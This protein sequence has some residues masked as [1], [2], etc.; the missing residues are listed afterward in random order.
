MI[1]VNDICELK[2]N[3]PLLDMFPQD[4]RFLILDIRHTDLF[5]DIAEIECS[6]GNEII[7]SRIYNFRSVYE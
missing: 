3:S 6:G 7:N 5:G 1:K 2:T 4:E